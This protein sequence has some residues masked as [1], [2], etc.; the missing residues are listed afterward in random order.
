MTLGAKATN[1]V[2]MMSQKFQCKSRSNP[3]AEAA[4]V[5]SMQDLH[6]L[7][8]LE[9]SPSSTDFEVQEA[10][11][12]LLSSRY[13]FKK[14][15]AGLAEERDATDSKL[16]DI[17][18]NPSNVFRKIRSSARS[19]SP[20]VKTMKVGD[21]VYSGE[22][23]ADGLFDSMMNLKAPNMEDNM[24]LPHYEEAVSTYNHITKLV[25]TGKKM[26]AISFSKGEEFLCN[27]KPSFMDFF[28][29]TSLHFLHLGKEGVLHFVFLLNAII[30]HINSSSV[31]ELNTIWAN[32]LF[33]GGDKDREH[34][35]SYRTISCCPLIAKA[36]DSCMVELYDGGWAAVQA[37]TQFQGSNSSHELA[38]YQTKPYSAD[39]VLQT[40]PMCI[41]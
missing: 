21:K 17:L 8:R 3:L 35:R 34:D 5:T 19:S 24:K 30:N 13:Q 6:H 31:A 7:R 4:A 36:L 28:T 25:S 27:L 9:A 10:R 11:G 40:T 32:I 18:S 12:K 41:C 23:V 1:K 33:K 39:D 14:V 37:S 20:A 22:V 38:A 16:H 29:A 15:R 26:P 2:I